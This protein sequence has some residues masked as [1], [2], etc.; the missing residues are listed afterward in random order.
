ML[1]D[2]RAV[3]LDGR[4]ALEVTFRSSVRRGCAFARGAV[5]TQK[6]A[7]SVDRPPPANAA[8]RHRRCDSVAFQESAG[9]STKPRRR[10][11]GSSRRQHTPDSV[12]RCLLCGHTPIDASVD[13]RFVTTSCPACGA[14]FAIEFNP[15]EQPELRARIER[16]IEP[17]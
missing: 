11:S 12:K 2:L 4:G 6:T 3:Y 7:A 14:V 15:P 13:G 16:I 1:S 9:R 5:Q 10:E 17:T 8:D